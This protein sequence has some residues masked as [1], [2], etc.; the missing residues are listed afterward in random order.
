MEVGRPRQPLAPQ[1]PMLPRKP[2]EPRFPEGSDGI[3]KA[4]SS[5][6]E[7]TASF[8]GLCLSPEGSAS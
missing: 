4:S 6:G 1:I 7:G 8:Q 3:K 5:S 2:R